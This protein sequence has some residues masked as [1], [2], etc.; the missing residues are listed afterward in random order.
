VKKSQNGFHTGS[1]TVY[2][3]RHKTNELPFNGKRLNHHFLQQT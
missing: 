1:P 2:I 3:L